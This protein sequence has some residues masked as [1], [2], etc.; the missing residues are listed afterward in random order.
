[1]FNKNSAARYK[2]PR[3]AGSAPT[4]IQ[5]DP[6]AQEIFSPLESIEEG[7]VLSRPLHT[8][9]GSVLLSD[10]TT[11][12]SQV[13]DVLKKLDDLDLLLLEALTDDADAGRGV[14]VRSPD[15][16][17]PSTGSMVALPLSRVPA[18]AILA[19]DIHLV[20]GRLYMTAGTVLSPRLLSLL[21]DLVEL[22][23]F[24]GQVHIV[25]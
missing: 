3:T 22:D 1:M 13:L 14:F 12:T 20:D 19:Q 21:Q 7:S 6:E 16:V 17:A 25:D 18:N 5:P 10:G 9:D 15:A 8:P 2:T 4:Q 24:E 23:R 11:L